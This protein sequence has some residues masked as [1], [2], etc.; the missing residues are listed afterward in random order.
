MIEYSNSNLNN[1]MKKMYHFHSLFPQTQQDR[2]RHSHCHH[3]DQNKLLHSDRGYWCMLR[4]LERE[5]I[6]G[7]EK[8]WELKKDSADDRN[9]NA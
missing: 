3:C 2:D 8:S 1:A 6:G 4:F 5:Q 7:N 9:D